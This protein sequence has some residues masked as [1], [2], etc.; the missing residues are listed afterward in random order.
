M[1]PL[2]LGLRGNNTAAALRCLRTATSTSTS[3]SSSSRFFRNKSSLISS[4]Y[5]A[6]RSFTLFARSPVVSRPFSSIGR[7]KQVFEE[8]KEVNV[9]EPV[10]TS[11]RTFIIDRQRTQQNNRNTVDV[12]DEEAN[13]EIIFCQQRGFVL[14][15]R[16]DDDED[17]HRTIFSE[18]KERA[19]LGSTHA[20]ARLREKFME[21]EIVSCPVQG[22]VS[23]SVPKEDS[24]VM[25]ALQR[26]NK[27]IEDYP[28][29]TKSA[30][31][32]SL[33][34]TGEALVQAA[35]IGFDPT[36]LIVYPLVSALWNG[37][38]YHHFTLHMHDRY[39]CSV[40]L[41]QGNPS[42]TIVLGKKIAWN[43]LALDPFY[44]LFFLGLTS[45]MI[46][47]QGDRNFEDRWTNEGLPILYFSWA[48]VPFNVWLFK[49]VPVTHQV[50]VGAFYSL[51]FGV[52][53]SF[54]TRPKKNE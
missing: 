25:T 27:A 26:Y 14:D 48:S 28:M 31:A 33:A 54:I 53:V 6:V 47:E 12:T 9:N 45:A 35:L 49:C 18:V 37:V 21:V 5:H 46:K 24:K 29:M 2:A 50:S 40:I 23:K 19:Q 22:F 51:V 43:K 32:G 52:V 15:E 3:C 10:K 38:F 4:N 36:R 17:T 39:N 1:T 20:M 13:E 8:Q 34:V 7:K 11:K 16:M 41:T 30:V 42:E 44:C